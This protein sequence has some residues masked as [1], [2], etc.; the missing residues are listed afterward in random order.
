MS[1]FGSA[2]L[3][4]FSVTAGDGA[5]IY[6]PPEAF[7]QTDPN[8]PR[9]PHTTKIDVF[10]YGIVMCEVITA[11]QPDP[12]LYLDRLEQVRRWSAPLHSLI[13]LCTNQSPEKRPTMAVVIDELNKVLQP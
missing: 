11:E 2:N 8:T 10:S 12:E 4:R 1:D 5:I 3:A 9:I 7:P 6:T 13:V